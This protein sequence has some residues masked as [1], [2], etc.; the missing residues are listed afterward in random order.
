MNQPYALPAGMEPELRT[1]Q[2]YWEAM[3]RGANDMPFWDDFKPSALPALNKQIALFDVF[4]EPFRLRFGRIVGAE[5]EERYGDE[6]RGQFVD[7]LEHRAPLDFLV[8]QA[9]AVLETSGPTYYRHAPDDPHED[10]YARLLLPMW[11]NGRIEM[12]LCA[13]AWR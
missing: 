5:I 4:D 8:S 1:V 10:R 9:S 7:E 11:G 6:L 13:Y 12:L 2:D 3:I